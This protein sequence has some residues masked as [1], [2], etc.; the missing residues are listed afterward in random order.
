MK[1]RL[2]HP[3]VGEIAIPLRPGGS[4]V[5]GRLG[6]KTDVEISWDPRISRRHCRLWEKDGRVWFEDLASRNGSW[7]GRD[8]ISSAICLQA[9]TAVL[10]GETV[11][12]LVPP[13][14]K[15]SLN[16]V[17][18]DTHE[19]PLTRAESL[20]LLQQATNTQPVPSTSGTEV[21]IDDLA[22]E[23][24]TSSGPPSAVQEKHTLRLPRSSSL[25]N[26]GA[27]LPTF[28]RS[29]SPV[30]HA[31]TAD[32]RES[33]ISE[34]L[35]LSASTG[36][37]IVRSCP[38]LVDNRR[39]MVRA[40]DRDDMRELWTRD[41]SKGGLF[42]ETS[43]PPPPDTELEVHLETPEGTVQLRAIVVHVLTEEMAAS[44]GGQSG[45]GVQFID[46]DPATRDTI[47]AYVEGSTD[48]F[49]GGSSDLNHIP[50]SESE[51]LLQ[52]ARRF[53]HDA[54]HRN[55]YE[56]LELSPTASPRQIN[57]AAHTLKHSLSAYLQRVPPP[58]A[59]RLK[60][61]LNVLGRLRRVMSHEDGRLEYDFRNGYI[62]AEERIQAAKAGHTPSLDT[63]RKTW[64]RVYPERV[65]RA[66]LLTRKAFTARQRQDM[67]AAIDAGRSALELNP[68]FE[69]LKQTVEVWESAV[70][71][72]DF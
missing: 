31:S 60:A 12:R 61:A 65:D 58:Q 37:H 51:E 10:I 50:A 13:N 72:R 30:P 20:A 43:T 21:P 56:A 46:L 6:A 29:S 16:P 57:D 11:L 8:R 28:H 42:I 22:C 7:I 55:F 68:F 67:A 63:L 41:I 48:I 24:P 45:I 18:E 4:L 52:R 2:M 39:V 70:D 32:L 33:L 62:R 3:A 15:N 54:E 64:N 25:V 1:I 14:D 17:L 47:Q 66:A 40:K 19:R 27:S 59:A 36:G 38:R 71:R 69:E 34:P 44:F 53:L 23:T 5:V 9:S 35:S 49:Q 26:V